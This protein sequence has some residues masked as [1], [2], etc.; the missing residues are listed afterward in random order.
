MTEHEIFERLTPLIREVTGVRE[1]QIKMDSG[2]MQDLGA[3]SV[4]LL[5]FS[6][7]IEEAFGITIEADEF[8]QQA[9]KRLKNEYERDGILTDEALEELRK[10]LPQ[11]PAEYLRPGL[12]KI[13]VPGVLNVAVFVHLIQRK[14]AGK[15][16]EVNSA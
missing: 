13:E 15:S 12:K 2:L 16:R 9:S 11:V 5:D 1:D 8:E 10:A 4:D 6:F 3:E 7:L 14:L